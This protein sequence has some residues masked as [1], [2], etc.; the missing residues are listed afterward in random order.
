MFIIRCIYLYCRWR[1]NYQE[2][3]SWDTINPN[4]TP[5]HLCAC[6]KPESRFPT[7]D[8]VVFLCFQWFEPKGNCSFCWYWQNCWPPLFKLSFQNVGWRSMPFQPNHRSLNSYF[9]LGNGMVYI[10][11]E[12]KKAHANILRNLTSYI[13]YPYY[14]QRYLQLIYVSPGLITWVWGSLF[15]P[16]KINKEWNSWIF[17][18]NS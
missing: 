4:L 13:N 16:K 7:P 12:N 11:V 5:P 15:F 9:F 17:R 2:V 18:W 6:P 1:S 8:V 14:F 3:N 10:L